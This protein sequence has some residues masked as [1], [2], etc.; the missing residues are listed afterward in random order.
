LVKHFEQLKHGVSVRCFSRIAK[1]QPALPW[2][3]QQAPVPASVIEQLTVIVGSGRQPDCATRS[4]GRDFR[5]V[6][7][8]GTLWINRFIR[9]ISGHTA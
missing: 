1:E 2:A 6:P 4:K 5:A 7:E 3:L 8:V 9:G